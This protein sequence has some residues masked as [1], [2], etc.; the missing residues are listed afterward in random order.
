MGS[1][2]ANDAVVLPK[3]LHHA[4]MSV[5]NLDRSLAFYCG[6]LGMV[7]ELE[8]SFAGGSMDRITRL[9]RT[10]GRAVLLS[11]GDQHLEL[12]EFAAPQP[13]E[14]DPFYP[15]CDYGISHFCLEVSNVQHAYEKLTTAGVIFHCP[16]QAFGNMKATY[17]RDPDGNV[18][19]F[20]ELPN[21][22]D[23]D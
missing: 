19:E 15:V 7:V 4:G 10:R 14:K 16:P 21:G 12:F 20:L 5:R 23:Q 13:Q 1:L 22:S 8:G 9:T 3:G 6:L 18:I 17:A 11:V 2:L